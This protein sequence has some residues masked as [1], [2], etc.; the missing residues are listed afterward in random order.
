MK[1]RTCPNCKIKIPIDGGYYF[2]ENDSMCCEVCKKIIVP[3]FEDKP[4]EPPP[5]T[6]VTLK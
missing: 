2:D 1:F 6:S 5:R 4:V 3:A